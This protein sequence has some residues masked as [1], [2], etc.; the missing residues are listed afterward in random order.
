MSI[1]VS[2]EAAD[3]SKVLVQCGDIER[4][5]ERQ[6]DIGALGAETT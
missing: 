2:P 3:S 1:Q 5:I 6:Q 4:D